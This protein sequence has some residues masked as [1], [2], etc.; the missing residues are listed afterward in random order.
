MHL[1]ARLRR[2]ISLFNGAEAEYRT[3]HVIKPFLRYRLIVCVMWRKNITL[4]AYKR[5][6]CISAMSG[7]R[8]ATSYAG[9]SPWAT[10]GNVLAPLRFQRLIAVLSRQWQEDII[11]AAEYHHYISFISVR[12]RLSASIRIY[13]IERFRGGHKMYR[14]ISPS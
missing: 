9:P 13:I 4:F 3:F 7:P 12:H 8:G 11:I 6:Q 2:Q 1:S 5:H 14:A 10:I